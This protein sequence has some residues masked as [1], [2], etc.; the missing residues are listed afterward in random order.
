LEIVHGMEWIP[1]SDESSMT[2]SP[3][4]VRYQMGILLC[5][6]RDFHKNIG[7]QERIIHGIEKE[8]VDGDRMQVLDGARARVII[9]RVI[10]AVD[11][12]GNRIVEATQ[13]GDGIYA[14]GRWQV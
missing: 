5:Y 2:A 13:S 9:Y 6:T 11:G 7:W 3:R 1:A 8:R 12:C 10:E 4:K 14:I